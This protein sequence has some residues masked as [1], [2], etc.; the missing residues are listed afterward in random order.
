[1]QTK[2]RMTIAAVAAAAV[3]GAAAIAGYVQPAPVIVDLTNRIA[4]GDMLSARYADNKAEYIGCGVRKYVTAAGVVASGFC[5]ARNEKEE[6][7]TCQTQN[8]ELLDV[9]EASAAYSFISFSW[10]AAGECTRIGFSNQSFY[11]PPNVGSN[12]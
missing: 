5:Q 1:M 6:Q 9:I 8:I 7:F 2:T 10:N 3:T 4:Y 11:L 12:L